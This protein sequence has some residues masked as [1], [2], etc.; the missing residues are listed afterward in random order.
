MG[1]VGLALREVGLGWLVGIVCFG[2]QGFNA[3][4]RRHIYR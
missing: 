1:G 3:F 4:L 2:Y